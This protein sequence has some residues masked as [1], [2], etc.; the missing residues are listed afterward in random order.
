MAQWFSKDWKQGSGKAAANRTALPAKLAGT[1]ILFLSIWAAD[2]SLQAQQPATAPQPDSAE[3]RWPLNQI[4]F[5]PEQ[6]KAAIG[7]ALRRIEVG[8]LTE[9]ATA[10]QRLFDEPEDGFVWSNTTDHP[11]SARAEAVRLLRHSPAL[12]E[13]YVRHSGVQAQALFDEA[14]SSRSP[15]RMADV[16]RR[17]FLTPAG[18]EAAN[19]LADRALER[20]HCE[21]AA[22]YWDL[23][24]RE[25]MHA[26]RVTPMLKLKAAFAHERSGH[27][28]RSRQ[29][30][31]DLGNA[32]FKLGG[33]AVE[34]QKWLVSQASTA[35]AAED[36]WAVPLG[37]NDRNAHGRGSVPL[38]KPLWDLPVIGEEHQ[39][40]AEA[41]KGWEAHKQSDA[42]PA[43][44]AIS[45]IAVDGA[46]VFRDAEG[47]HAVN[48]ASGA[49]LWK[50]RCE[51]S[52]AAL[53]PWLTRDGR[54]WV[55]LERAYAFNSIL[56]SLASDSEHIYLVDGIELRGPQPEPE[57]APSVIQVG[58]ARSVRTS[59]VNRLVALKQHGT[60]PE[61]VAWTI[62]GQPSAAG[63]Q[64]GALSG[65]FFLGPPLPA[66]GLLYAI[67]ESDGELSLVALR[68]QTGEVEW[69][70]G[71]AFTTSAIDQDAFRIQTACS[72]TYAGGRLICPTEV[73]VLVAVDATTGALEWAYSYKDALRPAPARTHRS[74]TPHFAG[75]QGFANLP[76]IEDQRIVYLPRGS[77]E[78]H[79]IDLDS[80]SPVWTAVRRDAEYVGTISDGVVLV[81][82]R[83]V[84]RGLSLT[85]GDEL[86]AVR[87]NTPTGHGLQLGRYYLI[88]RTDGLVLALDI[89]TG[90]QFGY[91]KP[92]AEVRLGNLIAYRDSVISMDGVRVA[93]FP[94]AQSLLDDVLVE[95]QANP[96]S[97]GKR[98]LAGE[99]QLRLGLL[100][101]ARASL[102]LVL[103]DGGAARDR[104]EA[105]ALMRELLYIELRSDPSLADGILNQLAQ[106]SRS[107]S[108]RGQYLMQRAEFQLRRG[109]I[110]EALQAGRE[111]A[112]LDLSGPLPIPDDTARVASAAGWM[113]DLLTRVRSG[114]GPEDA[115]R[116]DSQVESELNAA[117][118]TGTE[119]ALRTFLTAYSRCSQA[120]FARRELAERFLRHGRSQEAEL[121]LL[122]IRRDGAQVE[123]AEA[124]RLLVELWDRM[125]LYSEAG[126]MLA[127]LETRFA[128]VPVGGRRSGR[129]YVDAFPH[130][131]L[132]WSAWRR[133]VPVD[134]PVKHVRIVEEREVDPRLRETYTGYRRQLTPPRGNS[135]DLLDKGTTESGRFY[136]IDRDT[137]IVVETYEIAGTY[138]AAT[139]QQQTLV[140]HVLPIATANAVHG[141]SL[142]ERREAWNVNPPGHGR[143]MEVARIGPSGP[144]YFVFQT[145]QNLMVMSP[146]TGEIVWQRD[147]LEPGQGL[148]TDPT[149]GLIGDREALVVFSP[150]R[151]TYT[152]YSTHSGAELRRGK[153]DLNT[154]LHRIAFGRML[155]YVTAGDEP[156][157]RI[158]D[159]LTNRNVFDEP[160]EGK[161]YS[162]VRNAEEVLVVSTRGQVR[163][164]D[165]HTGKTQLEVQL[166]PDELQNVN[167]SQ[168]FADSQRY[169][170][171][172]QRSVVPT[173]L[174][175]YSYYVNDSFLPT[176]SVHGDLYAVDR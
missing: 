76:L 165:G 118:K 158:W 138:A 139:F 29:I 105:E 129:Q 150:D 106:L 107:P 160:Y 135:F 168:A 3:Q 127:E 111:F 77:Q 100:E 14:K 71:I 98:L 172:L 62:S 90:A 115:G 74:T 104:E 67:T 66:N 65:H 39:A 147:D 121:L 114:M 50:H 82:G 42:E 41:L 30:A 17:Y 123:Q 2:S 38:L 109:K 12:T 153:L 145:R 1:L 142:L 70:Q 174:N 161:S 101:P 75:H 91:S 95:L 166:G 131:S 69:M 162:S 141:L 155:L 93:A 55:D 99:L 21:L 173:P 85:T 94:Q 167:Q 60:G 47:V 7:L 56:G 151:C 4:L 113:P 134:W 103:Q 128:N 31:V 86:W 11:A 116:I 137:G 35:V 15:R 96:I 136:Q 8:D 120:N 110:E 61:R 48:V 83:H 163:I 23:I 6:H 152:V 13:A 132:S 176:V 133:H 170:L 22:R 54:N 84:C 16:V 80:G 117:L 33:R 102:E 43:S 32:K 34:A 26:S 87:T 36:E 148:F 9:A 45:P 24:L 57:D 10:L 112:G 126:A 44:M 81:V 89:A 159:P 73:G 40:L 169:Y 52:L 79:C 164:I 49:T 143:R 146:D 78:I 53:S 59:A 25:P 27:S 149:T 144:G 58:G 156:A 130:D 18:F 119:E 125:G 20:N 72:P 154:R 64:P 175:S 97:P 46:I 19:W 51:T 140:G 157:L 108:D 124:S 68:P 63:S 37:A 122:E 28:Q 5:R 88:P 171:N 92:E